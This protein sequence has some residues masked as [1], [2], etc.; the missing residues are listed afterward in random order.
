M[1]STRGHVTRIERKDFHVEYPGEFNARLV[2]PLIHYNT[3]RFKRLKEIDVLSRKAKDPS[4]EAVFECSHANSTGCPCKFILREDGT[5]EVVGTHKADSNHL[6]D[7]NSWRLYTAKV[8]LYEGIVH[9]P[10]TTPQKLLDNLFDSP[11]FIVDQFTP[12]KAVLQNAISRL[13]AKVFGQSKLDGSQLERLFCSTKTIA[14]EDLLMWKGEYTNDKHVSKR[15]VIFSSPFQLTIARKSGGVFMG[16]GTFEFVPAMF[17]Q[18][19]SIHAMIGGVVFPVAFVFMEEKTTQAYE[20]VFTRMKENG[21]TFKTVMCDYEKGSRAA[22]RNVYGPTVQIKGCWFHY[23]QAIMKRVKKIGLQSAYANVPTVNKAVRRLFALPFL[24]PWEVEEA[25]VL[26]ERD[27]AG[28][29]EESVERK[30]E[31]LFD[32]F[33]RTWLVK[34]GAEEWNQS[35]DVTF[36]SNNWAEA[37]H[38]SFA[39]RFARCHPNIRV[40]IEALRRVEN[41]VHVEWNEFKHRPR[42]GNA[43]RFTDELLLIMKT[44]EERWAGD[45]LGFIDALSRVPITILLKYEKK[46]LECWRETVCVDRCASLDTTER[47]ISEVASLLKNERLSLVEGGGHDPGVDAKA[48]MDVITKGALERRKRR[49]REKISALKSGAERTGRCDGDGCLELMGVRMDV[50]DDGCMR[51]QERERRV[52]WVSAGGRCSGRHGRVRRV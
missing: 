30:M 27:V 32:Y 13:K 17:K 3:H 20:I 52:F 5:G 28:F 46:Q 41:N 19:Y 10:F 1:E 24:A 26:I 25:F 2:H 8:H 51:G 44:R 48:Q 18:M 45:T 36:R 4:I 37:F 35:L 31:A 34:Y 22:I 40:A 50:V 43:D 23:T 47:R 29:A 33:R 42:N 15:I 9:D 11:D 6:N 49:L 39:R 16:D 12:S 7:V 21:V 38:S 14:G